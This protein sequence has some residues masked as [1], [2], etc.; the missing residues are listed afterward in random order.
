MGMYLG[1]IKRWIEYYFGRYFGLYSGFTKVLPGP[2][3]CLPH[4][5]PYRTRLVSE[6]MPK[7]VSDL[8]YIVPKS[9][10]LL[11]RRISMFF[12]RN[13]FRHREVVDRTLFRAPFGLYQ[14]STKPT[15][16]SAS[17]VPS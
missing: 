7:V 2:R 13:V 8:P 14:G 10:L 12:N 6:I 9:F 4:Q 3:K 16:V 17:L 11:G 5:S 15:K 1:I